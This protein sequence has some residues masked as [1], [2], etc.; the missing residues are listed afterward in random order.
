VSNKWFPKIEDKNVAD[1]M[2]KQGSY[3]ALI[4][5]GMSILGLALAY[6]TGSNVIT[7][8]NGRRLSRD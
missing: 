6:F 2:S 3:A 1:Q 8:T 5:L 4:Y 7:L